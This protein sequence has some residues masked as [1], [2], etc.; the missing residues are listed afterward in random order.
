MVRIARLY[1]N[2]FTSSSW[3]HVL[4]TAACTGRSSRP[5]FRNCFIHL[6]HRLTA[7]SG[8]CKGLGSLFF[9]TQNG[10]SGKA[11]GGLHTT[12]GPSWRIFEIGK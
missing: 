8:R 7:Q 2:L 1:T 11:S 3:I 12:Y 9:K 5:C 4:G 10:S 6:F